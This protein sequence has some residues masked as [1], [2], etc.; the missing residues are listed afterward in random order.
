MEVELVE[1]EQE[2]VGEGVGEE[3][4]EDRLVH[5]QFL[6]HICCS[7]PHMDKLTSEKNKV[8]ITYRQRVS[9]WLLVITS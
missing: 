8:Y 7:D 4:E 2:E 6:V 5:I 1:V 3:V 9:V